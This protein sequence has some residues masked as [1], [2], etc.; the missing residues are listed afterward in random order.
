M[1]QFATADLCDA[2]EG[3]VVALESLLAH[4]GGVSCFCGPVQT[5]KAFED[6]V[7]VK[8]EL[9]KPG[10]GRVLVVDAGGSLRCAM[11]GDILAQMAVDNGWA[12]IVVYGAIRDS[13]AIGGMPLGVMALGTHPMKSIKKG[14]G[15]VGISVTF[16]GQTIRPG[17]WLYADD[18][19]VILAEAPLT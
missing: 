17:V 19:G 4:F 6:N 12:G 3:R 13:A 11:V 15:D 8:A 5:V 1:T 2:H 10:D 9:A 18:D 16:A 14:A 7:L